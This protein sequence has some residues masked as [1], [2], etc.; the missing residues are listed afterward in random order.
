MVF[1]HLCVHDSDFVH[2]GFIRRNFREVG[3]VA[4]R[5]ASVWKTVFLSFG[6]LELSISRFVGLEQVT[7]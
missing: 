6:L 5:T 1:C 7:T 4:K 3:I 2:I